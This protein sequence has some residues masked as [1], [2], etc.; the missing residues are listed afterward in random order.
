MGNG[1]TCM[2]DKCVY[3]PWQMGSKRKRINSTGSKV[4]PVKIRLF[5]KSFIHLRV[6][7]NHTL[8]KCQKICYTSVHTFPL[9]FI[10]DKSSTLAQATGNNIAVYHMLQIK[11]TLFK[12]RLLLL[13]IPC[14]MYS[15]LLNRKSLYSQGDEFHVGLRLKRNHPSA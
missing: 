14:K 6:N 11:I 7:R 12:R 2:G 8:T 1:Y 15:K 10:N 3:Q 13:K 4:I 5:K 9:I